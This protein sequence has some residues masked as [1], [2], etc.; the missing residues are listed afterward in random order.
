MDVILLEEL[1]HLSYRGLHAFEP[2]KMVSCSYR[3]E[4]VQLSRG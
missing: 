4:Y 1:L 2:I 3:E